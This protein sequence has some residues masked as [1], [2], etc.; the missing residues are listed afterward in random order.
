MHRGREEETIPVAMEAI[1]IPVATVEAS[2]PKNCV[3]GQTVQVALQH[4]IE[5]LPEAQV[6]YL[7]VR[8]AFITKEP[9]VYLSGKMSD[10][11]C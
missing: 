9:G 6:A 7:V 1:H 8:D 10:R 3:P 11:T 4:H 5:H 2:G